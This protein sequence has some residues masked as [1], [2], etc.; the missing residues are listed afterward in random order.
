MSNQTRINKRIE[1]AELKFQ[2]EQ[3]QAAQAAEAITKAIAVVEEYRSELTDEQ[4]SDVMARFEEQ[5]QGITDF[6]LKARDKYA[7]K[8]I[9]LGN[10]VVELEPE[11]LP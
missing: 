9:A 6:L 3:I 7:N 8:L 1:N 11:D 4:Y 5:K 10:P 2:E